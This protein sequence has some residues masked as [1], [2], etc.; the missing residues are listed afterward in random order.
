[1]SETNEPI[2]VEQAFNT[3]ANVVWDAITK[4]EQMKQWFFDNIPSFDP[5]VGFETKFDVQ[6]GDRNFQHI[7]KLTEVVPLKKITYHWSYK[8]YPGD[9]FVT[10]ELNEKDGQT[11][12]RLINEGLETF[13]R[14]IPEFTR[15]SCIAGWEYFI[16]KNL[17]EFLQQS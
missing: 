2:I 8:E 6:S 9:G 4:V 12:L 1:M 15:E 11:V 10:F 14:D 17:K 3:S 16:K 5:V 13:P 7:W